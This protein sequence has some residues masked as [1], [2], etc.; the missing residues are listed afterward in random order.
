M[1]ILGGPE[2]QGQDGP[3]GVVDGA[4]QGQGGPALAQPGEGAAVDL[5]QTARLGAARSAVPGRGGAA[6][7]GRRHTERAA[8]PLDGGAAHRQAVELAQLLGQV[9]V[10]E[11]GIGRAHQRGDLLA[12]RIDQAAPRGLAAA[13]VHQ[14]RRPGGLVAALEALHLPDAQSQGRGRLLVGDALIAQRFQD[15]GPWGFLPSHDDQ[16]HEGMTFSLST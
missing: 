11:A 9:H 3:G 12:H 1:Q 5:H 8:Q 2:V 16:V 7:P 4:E 15:A 14:A 13:A 6:P 10:I